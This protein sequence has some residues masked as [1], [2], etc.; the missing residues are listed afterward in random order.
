MTPT[1]VTPVGGTDLSQA[2]TLTALLDCNGIS[3][4][5]EADD[6]NARGTDG[7]GIRR[8]D[9]SQWYNYK[10]R[11]FPQYHYQGTVIVNIASIDQVSLGED[12]YSWRY[13]VTYEKPNTCPSKVASLHRSWEPDSNIGASACADIMVVGIRGS[14]EKKGAGNVVGAIGAEISRDLPANLSLRMFFIDYT[15]AAVTTLLKSPTQYLDSISDGSVALQSL[16][17]QSARNCPHEKWIIAGYSQGALATHLIARYYSETTQLAKVIMVADPGRFTGNSGDL[18]GSAGDH[19]GVYKVTRIDDTLEPLP[20]VWS[21]RELSVCDSIDPICD[22]GSPYYAVVAGAMT[23]CLT[24]GITCKALLPTFQAGIAVHTGY[25]K[26]I[27]R[28][29]DVA[30]I[31]TAAAVGAV[32]ADG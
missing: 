7:V 22:F 32:H 1:V 23:T 12:A 3:A 2:P 24:V 14:G 16:L 15:A 5:T 4:I 26:D 29:A 25:A 27:Q 13:S 8:G 19:D 17:N 28:V 9:A 6:D 18:H 20:K 11:Y 21:D 31:A 10:V 30:T